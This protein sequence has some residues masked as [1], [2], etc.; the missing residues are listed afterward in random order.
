MIWPRVPSCL[1]QAVPV[2]FDDVHF[3]ARWF[4]HCLNIAVIARFEIAW[5]WRYNVKIVVHTSF[6]IRSV[7]LKLN[8][9]AKEVESLA[10]MDASTSRH[11]PAVAIPI[12]S[13]DGE[14]FLRWTPFCST[15]S[16]TWSW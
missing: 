12:T 14:V 3:H 16:W 1:C 5:V 6:R 11:R 10:A 7:D 4:A 2:I 8:V 9:T 15:W 13:I